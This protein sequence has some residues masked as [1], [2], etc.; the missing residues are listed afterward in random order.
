[1]STVS[2]IMSKDI[3]V[4]ELGLNSSALEV[5]KLMSKSKAGA[6]VVLKNGKPAGVITERDLLK[7]LSAKNK[8]PEDVSAKSIM[9]S[10]LVTVKAFDSI[11][12]AAKKMTEHGIKRLPVLEDDGSLAGMLSVTDIA[13]KLAKIL[14][15]DHTRYRS[16]RVMLDL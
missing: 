11:D 5:A 15:D 12:T 1:M 16:L 7:K 13:K 9:S 4:K 3:I 2:E 10:P 6:V 14:A 8:K